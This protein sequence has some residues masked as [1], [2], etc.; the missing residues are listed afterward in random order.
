MLL[1]QT[2]CFPLDIK[3]VNVESGQLVI[4]EEFNLKLT[5]V[6]VCI[7]NLMPI[8]DTNLIVLI[9]ILARRCDISSEINVP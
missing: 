4:L 7:I 5:K 8:S 3:L 1:E 9:G 2:I 6:H